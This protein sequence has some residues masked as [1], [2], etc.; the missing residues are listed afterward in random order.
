[1][2]VC[3]MLM[4]ALISGCKNRNE[5][6]PADGPEDP[7]AFVDYTPKATFTTVE[8]MTAEIPESDLRAGMIIKKGKKI[9]VKLILN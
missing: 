9:F 1:M 3:G 4:I 6:S 8:H 7:V 5:K 2:P